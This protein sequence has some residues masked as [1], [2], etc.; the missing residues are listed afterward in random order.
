MKAPETKKEVGNLPVV[1]SHM[2]PWENSHLWS[3]QIVIQEAFTL[4]YM[5]SKCIYEVIV[6]SV[7]FIVKENSTPGLEK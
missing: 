4:W 2:A 5:C 3:S 6:S 1:G 7:S